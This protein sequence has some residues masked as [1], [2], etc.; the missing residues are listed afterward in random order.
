MA[1]RWTTRAGLGGAMAAAGLWL[2]ASAGAATPDAAKCYECHDVVQSLHQGSKHESVACASCH[3]GLEA[4]LKDPKP[5]TRPVTDLS[6]NACG[7]CH[8][9]QLASFLQT[10]YHRPARDEKSQLTSRSPNP[11]WDKLMAGH[12]FTK[13][14]ALTRSHAW[15][16]VDHY[17]VDRAYGGRFQ[18]KEGWQYVAQPAGK[19]AW[20]Y[21][22]DKLPESNEHKA[23][24]PQTAAAANPV[25]L[26]CK[27]Q[28]QIL[29]WA[30]MGDPGVGAKWTAPPTSSSLPAA[31][32]TA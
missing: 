15:M 22:L 3:G 18:P 2:A 31:C 19:K 24:L 5:E 21:V 32:S 6:W 29:D 27:T 9:D 8:Q 12:G 25:C 14:H 20:D 4:H 7:T 1:K 30:Y 16:L 23:F 17:V 13:E 28:D 10:S 11:F 26:Q